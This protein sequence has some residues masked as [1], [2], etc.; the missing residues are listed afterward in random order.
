MVYKTF[1]VVL[2]S[3]FVIKPTKEN[4]INKNK[5][6]IELHFAENKAM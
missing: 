2:L 6:N 4:T 3:F 1:F 5:E